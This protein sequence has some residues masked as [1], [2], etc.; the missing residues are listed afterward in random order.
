MKTPSHNAPGPASPSGMSAA[1]A[2]TEPGHTGT[3]VQELRI[4]R[5]S[6]LGHLLRRYVNDSRQVA[7]LIDALRR[8]YNPRRIKAGDRLTITTDTTSSLVA[9]HYQPSIE[10]T[11][12]VERDGRSAFVA[13]I[14]S[15]PLESEVALIYGTVESTLYEAVLDAGE[16]PELI[17]AFTDIFQWDIDFFTETRSGDRFAVLFEKTFVRDRTRS[18]RTF[19]RYGRILAG[20]YLQKDA[21]YIAFNY[22]DKHDISRYYDYSGNSFQKTFLKSPLNY[23]RIASYFSGGRMHPILKIVRPHYGIDYSAARGTPVVAAADGKIIHLGW[24]GGYGHCVKIEHKNGTYVTLYGHLSRYA[25]GLRVGS[26]VVQSQV[27]GYVGATGLA[28]GPH[29][30]YTMYQNGKPINPLKIRPA[31]SNPLPR[32][33]LPD[34]MAKRDEL[35]KRL[36]LAPDQ[37]LT[38]ETRPPGWAR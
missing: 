12:V 6:T 16:S 3:E 18:R 9:L 30:H 29:L 33:A 4:R 34:F 23:R 36:G 1:I 28:T 15:L 2:P 38:F 19:L 32:E 31:A 10:R 11:I 8:V 26:R 25:P 5:G 17:M 20:A 22:P 24:L 21:S 35:L 7:A 37:Q 14:D 13:R 27:I